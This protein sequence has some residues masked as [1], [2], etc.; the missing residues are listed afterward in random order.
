MGWTINLHD[1][2][3]GLSSRELSRRTG[4]EHRTIRNLLA[5]H[6]TMHSLDILMQKGLGRPVD[7][8]F[9]DR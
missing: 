4:L 8:V 9:D 2:C 3:A 7:Q 6:G 1:W 5:G